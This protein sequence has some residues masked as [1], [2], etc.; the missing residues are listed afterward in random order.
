MKTMV[1]FDQV[2]FAADP[3][4]DQGRFGLRIHSGT[5]KNMVIVDHIDFGTMKTIRGHEKHDHAKY[6]I[7]HSNLFQYHHIGLLNDYAN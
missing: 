4:H 7:S 3:G 2:H 5:M 1:F 6:Y